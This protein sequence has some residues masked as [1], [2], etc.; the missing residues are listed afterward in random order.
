VSSDPI[1]YLSNVDAQL[2]GVIKAVGQYSIK[3]HNNA[4]QSLVESIIFQQ[5]AGT[6]ATA[7][8]GKF[9]K[10]YNE[11]MPTPIQILLSPDTELKSKV[12]LSS[13]RLC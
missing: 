12:S 11:V 3:V 5:L 9:I 1:K 7:I 10:Y 2:A 4:F 13:K 8:Y 6:A